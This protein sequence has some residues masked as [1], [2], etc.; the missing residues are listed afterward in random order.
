[1]ASASGTRAETERWFLKRG[2][3]HL[4][5]G[6]TAS[7]RIWSRAR[8]FLV[9]VLVME[10]LLPYSSQYSG[11]GEGVAVLVG[12]LCMIAS[13]YAFTRWRGRRLFDALS[14]VEMPELAFFVLVPGLITLLVERGNLGEALWAVGGNVV[15]LGVVYFIVG[16][17][18]IPMISWS[19]SMVVLH[20]VAVFR[21][22][23]KTLPL[24]LVLTVFMFIN[25]EIWQIA[26]LVQPPAFLLVSG[27]IT[28][29]GLGFVW[30]SSDD[31]INDVGEI[32]TWDQAAALIGDSPLAGV[33]IPD[34]EVGA[35]DLGR[36]AR[37]NL[38]LLIVV[39]LTTQVVL[40]SCGVIAF[41]I[42]L[43]AVFINAG[44]LEAWTASTDYT[45]VGSLSIGDFD[46][47][48]TIEHLRVAGLIGALSG[49]N[50]AVS[51]LTDQTYKETYVADLAGEVRENLAVHRVY[52]ALFK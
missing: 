4:I 25:A 37:R 44:V 33:G 18:L 46:M 23:A 26:N 24:L 15:L 7:T 47:L 31:I 36:G 9:A 6:Y 32:E 16:F 45:Q 50:V 22:L 40:V 14:E 1:M 34:G 5:S 52:A 51:A 35:A 30:L 43:G 48:V 17:G 21:L 13:V 8:P 10:T 29:A 41:Y 42:M 49:L 20:L 11:L 19:V 27:I 28:V 38:R 39:S 3:P 12:M 2:V